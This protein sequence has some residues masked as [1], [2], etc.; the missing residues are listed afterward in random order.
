MNARRTF[1]ARIIT[2]VA[3]WS[4][5]SGFR[6]HKP[7][8]DSWGYCVDLGDGHWGTLK[9]RVASDGGLVVERL[10]VRKSSG[11][12]WEKNFLNGKETRLR[13]EGA[14]LSCAAHAE[15]LKSNPKAFTHGIDEAG[16]STKIFTKTNL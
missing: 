12:S 11:L 10:T 1:L 13:R 16:F 3:G 14:G 5:L 6:S 15:L 8:T 2:A 4:L 9:G 7:V